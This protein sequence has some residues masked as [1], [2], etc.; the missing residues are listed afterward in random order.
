MACSSWTTSCVTRPG[1]GVSFAGPVFMGF[2]I[3]PD[4]ERYLGWRRRRSGQLGV[5]HDGPGILVG[6][7]VT[8]LISRKGH[9]FPG[10]FL[11]RRFLRAAGGRLVAGMFF[12]ITWIAP[13]DQRRF[14]AVL[15][16]VCI[17]FQTSAIIHGGERKRTSWRPSAVCV[18]LQP[19]HRLLQIFGRHMGRDA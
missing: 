9:E 18:D 7:S 2:I 11:Y 3:R 19:V 4:P 6:L 12:Q 1:A 8:W 16:P 15:P 13:G 17:L 14:C 5:C 10:R